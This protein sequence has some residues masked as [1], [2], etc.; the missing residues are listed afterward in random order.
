MEQRD[1]NSRRQKPYQ[2]EVYIMLKIIFVLFL[3]SSNV[4]TKTLKIESYQNITK[5]MLLY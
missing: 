4:K 5:N 1:G 2:T 3:L